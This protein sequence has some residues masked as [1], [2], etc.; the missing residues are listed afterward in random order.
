MP[1]YAT[2]PSVSTSWSGRTTPGAGITYGSPIAYEA[3]AITYGGS[4][5]F[6]APSYSTRSVP[7]TSY[8]SRVIPA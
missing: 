7:S 1:T 4:G 6:T 2:R 8:T 5:G 3:A